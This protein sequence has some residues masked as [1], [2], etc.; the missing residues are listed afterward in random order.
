MDQTLLSLI[1]ILW[2]FETNKK[3]FLMEPLKHNMCQTVLSFDQNL[4]ETLENATQIEKQSLLRTIWVKFCYLRFSFLNASEIENSMSFWW[5]V[6]KTLCGQYGSNC[7][8]R[9]VRIVSW[10][11]IARNIAKFNID[12]TICY[13]DKNWSKFTKWTMWI[14]PYYPGERAIQIFAI[15]ARRHWLKV[16]S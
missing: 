15:F 16:T 9:T 7:I 11:E 4:L 6:I 8:V 10:L 14:S 3:Y 5:S 2:T 1:P 12:R 13:V